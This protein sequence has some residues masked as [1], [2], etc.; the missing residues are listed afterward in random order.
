VVN[1]ARLA[2][3]TI[4]LAPVTAG[5]QQAIRV[6]IQAESVHVQAPTLMFIENGTLRHLRDGRTVRADITVRARTSA[7]GTVVAGQH[8]IFNVSYDLWEERFAVSRA[9]T[10][11]RSISHLKAREAEA[12]CVDNT[13]LPLNG[14]VHL[15]RDAPFW[16]SVDYEVPE[17]TARHT[18]AADSLTLLINA[19]SRLK[20]STP[21]RRS[22]EAGPFRL[23]GL[24]P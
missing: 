15:G 7:G 22:V 23:S 18:E 2:V 21:V 12:W 20:E 17:P 19:L 13:P 1:A 24:I 8:Q 6:R 10:P 14:L 3:V 11:P 9:G 16:V 4:A 5:A